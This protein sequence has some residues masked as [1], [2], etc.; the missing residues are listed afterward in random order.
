MK[1]G[2]VLVILTAPDHDFLK[3]ATGYYYWLEGKSTPQLA[4]ANIVGEEKYAHIIIIKNDCVV[5]EQPL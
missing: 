1:D 3:V 4:A 2:P 5:L